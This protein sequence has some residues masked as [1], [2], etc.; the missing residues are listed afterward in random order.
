M[1]AIA[2]RVSWNTSERS[3][4]FASE[5][6][7]NQLLRI[8]EVLPK[9]TTKRDLLL[10]DDNCRQYNSIQKLRPG[11]PKGLLILLTYLIFILTQ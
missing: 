2:T 3:H 4:K 1:N 9:L 6:Y 8:H 10:L 11:P 7:D 5:P